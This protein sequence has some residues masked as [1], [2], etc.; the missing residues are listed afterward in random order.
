MDGEEQ[1]A[2]LG[3]EGQILEPA[4]DENFAY[5]L[6]REVWCSNDFLLGEDKMKKGMS[7]GLPYGRELIVA[8]K[9]D[10]SVDDKERQPGTITEDQFQRVVNKLAQTN[11]DFR[12]QNKTKHKGAF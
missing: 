2:G 9:L 7:L 11:D 6:V 5:L 12:I 10:D 4:S 8:I 3:Y 1:G